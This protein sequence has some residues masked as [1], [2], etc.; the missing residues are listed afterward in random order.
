[1]NLLEFAIEAEKQLNTPG[2]GVNFASLYLELRCESYNK[3]HTLYE[4]GTG[5]PSKDPENPNLG[6]ILSSSH[7]I[8][9]FKNI[10][11]YWDNPQSYYT[12]MDKKTKKPIKLKSPTQIVHG[13]YEQEFVRL[14]LLEKERVTQ[15]VTI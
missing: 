12:P 9:Y 3:F 13:D 10:I 14:L 8:D 11:K 7:G 1:M 6:I 4:N 15:E 5:T 2:L